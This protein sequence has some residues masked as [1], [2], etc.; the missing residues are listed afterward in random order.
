MASEKK[1]LTDMA[2][3]NGKWIESQGIM[4][5]DDSAIPNLGEVSI[6]RRIYSTN[7]T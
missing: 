4:V 5:A 2:A 6:G 7:R 3:T 1:K